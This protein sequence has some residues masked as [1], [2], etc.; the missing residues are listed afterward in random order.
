MTN[1]PCTMLFMIQS[2]VKWKKIQFF[3]NNNVKSYTHLWHI[4]LTQILF[5]LNRKGFCVS[6][7]LLILYYAFKKNV[8]KIPQTNDWILQSRPALIN[9]SVMGF[10]F[11][12]MITLVNFRAYCLIIFSQ[13]HRSHNT[14][15]RIQFFETLS[16][17]YKSCDWHH[18]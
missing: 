17:M 3:L 2:E 10:N 12:L 18:D 8:E 1:R 16:G 15:K 6:H 14:Q 4:N 13:C 5:F 7:L 9:R 11:G